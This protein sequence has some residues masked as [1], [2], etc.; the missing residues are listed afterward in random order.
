MRLSFCILTG[1]TV[2]RCVLVGALCLLATPMAQAAQDGYCWNDKVGWI[3]F[4]GVRFDSTSRT[5]SGTATFASGDG[6][7]DFT[8]Q[9]GQSIEM[10]V[11]SE[12]SGGQYAI[13]GQAFSE[14]IG[15]IVADHGG[16]DPAAFTSAGKLTGN[17]WSN[18]FGWLNCSE[19]DVG[20]ANVYIIDTVV[21]PTVRGSAGRLSR[22]R[23]VGVATGGASSSETGGQPS[24]PESRDTVQDVSA[25][26]NGHILNSEEDRSPEEAV[27]SRRTQDAI[28]A[29]LERFSGANTHSSSPTSP[30]PNVAD[31]RGAA[32]VSER[33][34][35]LVAR[36]GDEEVLFRDVPVAA[37]FA[38][39]VAFLVEDK[40]ATGYADETGKPRGEFGVANPVTYAEVLKMA[41]QASS[42]GQPLQTASADLTDLPPPR[43][44]SARD[45]W[46]SAYVAQA[47]A[48]GLALF[49][50]DLNVHTPATRG[51]V[52]EVMLDVMDIPPDVH[53][54]AFSDVPADHRHAAAIATAAL[55]GLVTGDTDST[56]SPLGTFRPNDTINR[57]E[58]AKIMALAKEL[59]R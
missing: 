6:E 2:R 11:A 24:V 13:T 38:P 36:V 29:I 59:M 17:F 58:V 54:L 51:A 19:S 50:P 49:A 56:G 4:A 44:R 3:S 25:L 37:W 33:R 48:L 9:A 47:E 22:Q 41:L 45:T 16:T 34:G 57:A 18:E 27:L 53:A 20:S 30:E 31:Q 1:P 43:N 40:I 7:I 35:L 28:S 5:L 55:L 15:W 46:A 52:I 32:I 39:Y 23:I 42:S 14:R 8:E 10:T 21:P 12:L 26:T